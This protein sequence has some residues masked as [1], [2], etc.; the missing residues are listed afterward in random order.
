MAQPSMPQHYPMQ[1]P[2][3]Q[4]PSQQVIVIQQ[5]A[6]MV[7][8]KNPVRMKCGQCQA[9]ISTSVNSSIRDAGWIWCILCCL[10]CCMPE[11][12]LLACCLSGFK[13]FTHK[14]PNCK[15]RLGSYDPPHS[16]A[17]ICCVLF[18]WL[19]ILVIM[20][21]V[22]IFLILPALDDR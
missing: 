8:G 5:Q 12:G 10:C 18:G 17:E 6:A 20:I 21:L 3:Q 14:C 2:N 22:I 11:C 13:R 1:Q 7:F 19:V 4:A 15:G 9:D 16:T